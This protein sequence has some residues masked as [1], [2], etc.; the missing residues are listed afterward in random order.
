MP[1]PCSV[2]I[3]ATAC[4]NTS[5]CL[6]TL[7]LS[8][9]TASP[10]NALSLVELT[11]GQNRNHQRLDIARADNVVHDNSPAASRGEWFDLVQNRTARAR[12]IRQRAQPANAGPLH[13]RK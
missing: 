9:E 5:F 6:R 3:A 4:V 2:P 13:I 11:T 7:L 10:A 1:P 12:T 8:D